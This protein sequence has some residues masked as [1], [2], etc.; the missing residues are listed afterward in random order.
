[1]QIGASRAVQVAQV[2]NFNKEVF[3]VRIGSR[4][5]YLL[6]A[7]R[8]GVSLIVFPYVQQAVLIRI[9]DRSAQNHSSPGYAALVGR[10]WR[11]HRFLKGILTRHKIA[12][13]PGWIVPSPID[14][15]KWRQCS[16]KRGKRLRKAI[17]IYLLG[18]VGLAIVPDVRELRSR[19]RRRFVE[20][21]QGLADA[22]SLIARGK[23][24]VVEH[25]GI[26]WRRRREHAIN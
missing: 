16:I 20:S 11:H 7:N 26:Q 3:S 12:H 2:V 5:S 14:A 1:M 18:L 9:L 4:E 10:R 21:Q 8:I 19:A 22:L 25:D 13:D 17:Q 24:S 6:P 23:C 15:G